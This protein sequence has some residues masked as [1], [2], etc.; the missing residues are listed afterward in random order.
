MNGVSKDSEEHVD[1]LGKTNDC[2][3]PVDSDQTVSIDRLIMVIGRLD[4]EEIDDEL[5][6]LNSCL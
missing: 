4:Y 1:D 2:L 5:D 6:G 3:E